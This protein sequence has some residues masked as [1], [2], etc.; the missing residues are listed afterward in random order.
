MESGGAK[1][2]S[3]SAS[4]WEITKMGHHIHSNNPRPTSESSPIINSWYL[5]PYQ[6]D[7]AWYIIDDHAGP[8]GD[9]EHSVSVIH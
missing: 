7:D 1:G 2:A 8:D 6:W 3:L 4:R 5:P 9:K